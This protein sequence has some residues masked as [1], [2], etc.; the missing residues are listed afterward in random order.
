MRWTA[1]ALITVVLASGANTAQ[2]DKC[3]GA[4]LKAVGKKEAGLLGCQSKVAA[5]NDTS[6]LS[7]CE[8]KVMGK[9]AAAFGK[10]GA[11]A[12]DQTVCENFADACDS[13]MAAFMTDTF[14]SKCE[15]AKRKAA[16]KLAGEELGCYSKAAA[17]G[18]ALD[19]P[20]IVKAQGKFAFALAKAGPCPDGGSVIPMRTPQ[21]VVE[22]NCVQPVVTTVGGMVMA[23]CPSGRTCAN[24]GIGCGQSCGTCGSGVC[25]GHTCSLFNDCDPAQGPVCVAMSGAVF[26]TCTLNSQCAAGE[27][28]NAAI[29]SLCGSGPSTNACVQVCPE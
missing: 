12:G 29:P 22:N 17:K 11:C 26:A 10:A 13:A 2:A 19:T 7:A 21:S 18:V 5:T 4:K 23:V 28:C 25:S 14:P 20:C 9:F 8:S 6:G 1:L 27:V 24:G 16:G 3:G 15:A